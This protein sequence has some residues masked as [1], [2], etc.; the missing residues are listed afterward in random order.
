MRKDH[1]VDEAIMVL[2]IWCIAFIGGLIIAY[3]CNV[4]AGLFLS[5]CAT[6]C[7]AIIL[8]YDWRNERTKERLNHYI[9]DANMRIEEVMSVGAE[10]NF[11]NRVKA[12]LKE[13]G[14]WYIKYWAGSRFTKSGVPDILACVN[15]YF[16]GIEVK[17][18]TGT[19]SELQLNTID[20][21]RKSG[22]FAVVLYPS[23]FADFKKFIE[24]LNHDVFDREMEVIFK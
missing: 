2:M 23:G 3:E 10:K 12:F 18:Q 13:E 15:G 11:E 14:A 22:G 1:D 16:V 20:E 19:P 7:V 5:G 4:A 6:V 17:A 21:I 9:E 24:N 8:Y